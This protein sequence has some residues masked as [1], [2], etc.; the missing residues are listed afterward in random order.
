[1]NP[2]RKAFETRKQFLEDCKTLT[3]D[4]YADI[5]RILKK[6]GIS[7]SE[8]SNGIFFDLQ[9]VPEDAFAK[10]LSFMDF[11]KK[12]T[13]DEETREKVLEELRT[14]CHEPKESA[15]SSVD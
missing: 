2:E 4:Q 15:P 1:M 7:Y 9:T 11:C 6:T 8:N 14:E 12:Q 5:F 10:L 13:A 3:Q